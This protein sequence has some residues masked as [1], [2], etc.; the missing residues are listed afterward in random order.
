M[1][2][3]SSAD[4]RA[5]LAESI[6]AQPVSSVAAAVAELRE[7]GLHEDAD[8]LDVVLAEREKQLAEARAAKEA[9]EAAAKAKAAAAARAEYDACVARYTEKLEKAFEHLASYADEARPAMA[10]YQNA[11]AYFTKLAGIVGANDPDLPELPPTP[12]V[13]GKSG[14][15]AER[16]RGLSL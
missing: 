12:G 13:Y 10:E 5:Q 9:E 7:A 15:M 1:S 16:L 8:R 11:A 6:Q 3:K 14:P 2:K 4:L